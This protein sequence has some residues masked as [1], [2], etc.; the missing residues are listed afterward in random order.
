MP[1]RVTLPGAD[2]LF[3]ATTAAVDDEATPPGTNGAEHPRV[4]PSTAPAAGGDAPS[5]AGDPPAS[6]SVPTL[7]AVRPSGRKRHE[8]KITVYISPS[9]L[10]ELEKVRLD[11]RAS[12]GLAV[13][14]GRIVREA[15]SVVLADFAAKAEDS[16][17]VRRLRA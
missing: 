17:L 12:H 13:D 11:L 2:E 6:G 8:E 10:I 1:R 3:R 5:R 16:I 7:A 14:R 9:E 15:L 4:A